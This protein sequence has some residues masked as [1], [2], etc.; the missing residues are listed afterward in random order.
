MQIGS[1]NIDLHPGMHIF[2]NA[3][4]YQHLFIFF[5][6]AGYVE[7]YWEGWIEN[8]ETLG[9]KETKNTYFLIS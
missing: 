5:Y 1:H 4:K 7:L 9:R 2:W 6:C 3:L 8:P